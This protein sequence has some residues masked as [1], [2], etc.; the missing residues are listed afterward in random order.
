MSKVK[1]LWAFSIS[2]F[3]TNLFLVWFLYKNAPE[4]RDKLRQKKIISKLH[5]DEEQEHKYRQLVQ[6]HQR[7]IHRKRNELLQLKRQ[8]YTTLKVGADT[9][10]CHSILIDIGNTQMNMEKINLKHFNDI[11]TICDATQL[12]Y[13]ND[14]TEELNTIFSPP[15]PKNEKH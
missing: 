4:T 6:E 7:E 12:S 13:F 10:L 5:F 3:V 9:T 15:R 14:L 2:L 8:Y 11:K 1:I